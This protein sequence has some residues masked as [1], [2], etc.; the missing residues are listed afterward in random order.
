MGLSGATKLAEL[1]N[2]PHT[3]IQL[4]RQPMSNN[5]Y[6][7]LLQLLLNRSVWKEDP[8]KTRGIFPAEENKANLKSPYYERYVY[9][10][11]GART[12]GSC[13]WSSNIYGAHAHGVTRCRATATFHSF[14]RKTLP[15]VSSISVN[16]AEMSSAKVEYDSANWKDQGSCQLDLQVRLQSCITRISNSQVP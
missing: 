6:S 2:L 16:L 11:K 14:L 9:I 15:L 1:L 12:E 3:N 13:P 10:T 7:H 8:E 5:Q 4:C